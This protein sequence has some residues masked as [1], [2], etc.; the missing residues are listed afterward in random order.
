MDTRNLQDR[1][2]ILKRCILF[3]LLVL[4]LAFALPPLLRQAVSAPDAA[5][6]AAPVNPRDSET[7]LVVLTDEGLREMSMAQYL[8]LTL[9]AEMP[10]AFD[11][12]ALKAQA[13]ALRSYALYG[14]S[15]RKNAHPEADVCLDFHC[16]TAGVAAGQLRELW[17]DSFELYRDKLLSAIR[18][19][20]GEYLSWEGGAA[21]CMFHSSSWLR[22]EDSGALF[23]E[24]P[25]LQSVSSPETDSDTPDLITEVEVAPTEFART[26]QTLYPEADFTA[27]PESWL[28]NTV[29]TRSGRVESVE[30]GGAVL[31]GTTLR[32][33]FSLRSTDFGLSFRDDRFIFTVRGYGHGVGL[34]QYGADTLARQGSDYQSILAHYY[35]G[36]ELQRL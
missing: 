17:G 3:S 27:P 1:G 36:T 2:I 26:V 4:V 14:Q 6:D 9:P 5:E 18:D 8:A 12:E 15:H 32:A 23:S 22:T 30:V 33:L 10:A 16:C 34:S 13:C 21:L 19:T 28:G 35:P 29:Q 11:P 31:T 7:V 24:I 25:Y 20:D